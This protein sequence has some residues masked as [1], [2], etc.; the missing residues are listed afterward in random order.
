M[1][2]RNIVPLADIF[3]DKDTGDTAPQVQ[4]SWDTYDLAANRMS[5]EQATFIINSQ[6]PLAR[7]V[8]QRTFI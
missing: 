4:Q 8:L 1:L 5:D 3:I 7:G 2:V 6:I